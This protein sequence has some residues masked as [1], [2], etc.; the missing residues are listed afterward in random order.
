MEAAGERWHVGHYE[1]WS[2]I[3]SMQHE[4]DTARNV[5]ITFCFC[6]VSNCAI[7]RNSVGRLHTGHYLG[8]VRQIPNPKSQIPSVSKI[9]TTKLPNACPHG[10]RSIVEI[11]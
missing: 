7:P 4:Q 6:L 3:I 11:I 8:C 2:G 10:M 1:M 5:R 9:G